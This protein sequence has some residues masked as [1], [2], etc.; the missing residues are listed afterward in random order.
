MSSGKSYLCRKIQEIAQQQNITVYYINID[1]IRRYILS[2]SLESIDVSIRDMLQHHFGNIIDMDT[3]M[4]DRIALG[5]II[6]S[7]RLAMQ[8]YEAC[9]I[10]RMREILIN[11]IEAIKGT[12]D[13]ILV[14]RAALIE[15]NIHDLVQNNVIITKC[16][17]KTLKQRSL[18]SDLP[19]IQLQHRHIYF[20]D[21]S[22]KKAYLQKQKASIIEFN[23]SENPQDIAYQKLLYSLFSHA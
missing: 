19:H 9:I 8:Q 2:Y 18:W 13:I 6:F 1:D 21:H 3:S 22:L 20:W 12:Y 15:N 23:T 16:T 5:D 11:K 7:N 17:D 14:E 4:I 10:P